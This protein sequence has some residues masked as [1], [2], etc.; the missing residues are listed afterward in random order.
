MRIK[1]DYSLRPRR[2]QVRFRKR[3]VIENVER[4]DVHFPLINRC[5]D[6]ASPVPRPSLSCEGIKYRL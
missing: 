6:I 1:P 2:N 5:D 4:C 3:S